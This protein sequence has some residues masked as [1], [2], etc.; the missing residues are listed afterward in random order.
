MKKTIYAADLFCGAG[1]TSSGLL[2]AANQLGLQVELVAVNHWDV[3]IATHTL[4]HPGI[5]HVNSDLEKVDPRAVVP[6]GKLDL[7]VASPECTHFSKARGGK[8]MSKQ[9]RASVKYIL[10][11]VTALEVKNVIIENV[12]E[13]TDWGPLHRTHSGKCDGNHDIDEPT[14]KQKE[15][16]AACHFMKPI[17]KRKG[18]YFHRFV[19]KM[20]EHGYTVKWRILNAADYGD[21]TTRKRLFI[22]CRKGGNPV[23]PEP[24]HAPASKAVDMF[25]TRKTWRPARDIIDWTIKGESIFQRKRPLADNT[26]RR[27]MAGLMKFGGKSFVIGQQSG[28]APRSTDEPLPTVAAAGAISF[29]EPFI[30]TTN[31]T[32]TNRSQPRS[33]DQ[34]IPAITGQGQ[35]GL[36]EP[37]VVMLN[38]TTDEAIEK[39]NRSVDEP[40]PTVTGTPHVGLVEPFIIPQFS[41]GAPKSVD[42]PLGAITTTSRG[43]GLV[44]P[45]IIPFFGERKNQEPRTHSINDPLPAITSHGAGA[46]VE[47]FIMP[48]NHGKNDHRAYSLDDPMPTVT[49]VD[50]WSYVEP[51]LVEYYGTGSASSVDDP[52]KTQTGRDRFGLVQPMI[53]ESEGKKYLL[54]IRFRMLQPHELARAMSFPK[55]YKFHGNREQVVKQI[56]NAVPVELAAALCATT[57]Q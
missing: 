29:I 5:R 50:A 42:E 52:L 19:R 56:G 46:L 47:P 15:I 33:V 35:I 51:Y 30:V 55:G 54:D 18:E 1:G 57:L 36:A 31:W 4:N 34:P 6:G 23:F 45:F 26:M 2:K 9:S 17:V 8:P 49:S 3:A 25:G 41:E 22:M 39:S 53:F 43:I 10:R 44:E 21:P 14:K 38:G 11:W 24:T 12:P 13:F 48:V 27:I 40:L 32:A 7:L 16:L 28:A 37:F 20:E